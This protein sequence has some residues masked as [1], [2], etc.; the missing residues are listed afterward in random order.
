VLTTTWSLRRWAAKTFRESTSCMV[1]VI[2]MF[3]TSALQR[4]GLLHDGSSWPTNW[5]SPSSG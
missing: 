5:N 3:L 1:D 2:G 4:S